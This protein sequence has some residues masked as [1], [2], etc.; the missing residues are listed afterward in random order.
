[1]HDA[2]DSQG[3][4]VV[5]EQAV[6]ACT[7]RSLVSTAEEAIM[8]CMTYIVSDVAIADAVPSNSRTI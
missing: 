1:M 7:E 3:T 4:Y 2:L 8:R 5:V 6:A